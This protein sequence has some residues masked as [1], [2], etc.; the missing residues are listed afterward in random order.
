L[1]LKVLQWIGLLVSV[2]LIIS[3]P[4][5]ELNVRLGAQSTPDAIRLR[6]EAGDAAAQRHLGF[7]Y[8][9]GRG[10]EQDDKEA[11]RWLL[12]AAEQGEPRAQASLGFAYALGKGV[13]LDYVEAYKWLDLAVG[14]ASVENRRL[15]QRNR[16]VVAS[17]MTTVQLQDARCRV[18]GWLDRHKGGSRTV[19]RDREC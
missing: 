16:E 4:E 13:A 15:F 6:A 14:R 11:A 7:M 10:V 19:V 2:A 8:A 5:K 12:L 9:G 3:I 17:A 1:E 18:R